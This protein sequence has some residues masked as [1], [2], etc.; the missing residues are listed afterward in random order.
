MQTSAHSHRPFAC[1]L[2]VALAAV[3][4]SAGAQP[5]LVG[6]SPFAPSGLASGGLAAPAQDFELAGSTS[7]G[8]N[9]TICIYERQAKRSQWIPV[10][11]I[12]DGIRVVSYDATR[13][14]AVVVIGG[15]RKDIAM[16]KP[17][18]TGKGA[19]GA[20]AAVAMALPAAPAP[21]ADDSARRVPDAPALGGKPEQEQREARM[22]VSDL[23]EIGVQQRKAYQDA[24][25][26]AA[27]GTPPAPSN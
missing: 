4:A 16:R 7:E 9:V 15:V 25:Q 18:Y 20:P 17:T 22:L 6:N 10:G 3:A 1:T 21:V 12:S 14:Q 19:S 11:G 24:R 27:A 23:L 8:S 5:T 26:K 13:D 2:W